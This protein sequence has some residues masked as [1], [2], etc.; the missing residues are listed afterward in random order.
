MDIGRVIKGLRLEQGLKLEP[1]ANDLDLATSTLSRI[2]SGRHKPSV[3]N[4]VRI[5]EALGVRVSDIFREAESQVVPAS[6]ELREAL[7][8][9]E[10]LA[11]QLRKVFHS[12]DEANRQRALEL[13]RT[14]LRLQKAGT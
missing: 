11:L 10:D 12:L 1:L 14:L 4:L 2:E 8:E 6:A 7:S 9:Y 3:D 13:L 5:A